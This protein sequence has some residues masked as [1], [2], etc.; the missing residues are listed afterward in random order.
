VTTSTI[1]G[2]PDKL[3]ALH[4]QLESAFTELV[5]GTDWARMLT[6]AARFH[7]YSPANILL[8]LRQRQDA[9]RVAGYRT[10]QRL[11]RQVR[12]GERAVAILAPC[13]YLRPVDDEN[14][15]A[16]EPRH[17][18]RGFKIA[19]VFDISQ[20]DGDPLPHVGPALLDGDAPAGLWD[21][22]SAQVTAA[23]FELHRDDCRPAN[24]RT[25][26]IARTV[27]VRP[28]VSEAQATK[29]LAHE[30]AHVLLH[31]GTAYALGC[32]GLVEVEAESVA[33]IVAT[34][35]GMPT[36]T[37]SLPYVAHWSD[38]NINAIKVTADRVIASA[39]AILVGLNLPEL[40]QDEPMA[41]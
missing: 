6:A 4:D 19:H 39:R 14:N 37:Y 15:A 7:H 22:L 36:D 28:D 31:D 2:A 29:T 23:G 40:E 12:R 21:A 33:Y 18:L 38:G 30:L 5:S 35:A 3:R 24:G 20:T 25:D 34:A 27:T 17:V 11:G 41:S 32:R 16:D 9:T 10:W 26:Y 13:T 8:I 1:A